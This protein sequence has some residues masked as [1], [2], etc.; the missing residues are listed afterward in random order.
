MMTSAKTISSSVSN[1]L[2]QKGRSWPEHNVM[3]KK[4]AARVNISLLLSF[5][6][7][8]GLYSTRAFGVY[9]KNNSPPEPTNCGDP[10]TVYLPEYLNF[11]CYVNF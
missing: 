1:F 6:L 3:K 7:I 8:S 4:I 5:V 10:E 11:D 2:F 9:K